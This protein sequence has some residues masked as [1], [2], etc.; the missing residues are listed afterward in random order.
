[1]SALVMPR[2]AYSEVLPEEQKES[3]GPFLDRTVAWFAGHGITVERVMRPL[4]RQASRSILFRW[5]RRSAEITTQP[6]SSPSASIHTRSSV[7]AGNRSV[8]GIT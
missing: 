8:K 7:F 2:L 5:I 3:A 6:P 4:R 1:M